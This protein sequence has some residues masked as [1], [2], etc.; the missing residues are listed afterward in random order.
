MR[1]PCSPQVNSS[2]VTSRPGG[3]VMVWVP[4]VMVEVV[5]VMVEVVVVVEVM[6][7]VEV[8]EWW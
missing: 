8:I 5:M 7:M 6:V 2:P 4:K 1:G 3:A